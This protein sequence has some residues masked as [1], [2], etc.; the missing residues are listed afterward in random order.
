MTSRVLSSAQSGRRRPA[1]PRT[2]NRL[3]KPVDAP[4][5]PYAD[6]LSATLHKLGP[7]DAIRA[8]VKELNAQAAQ[9]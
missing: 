5:G 2:L 3:Q 7:F 8:K 6:E 9:Q 4:Y 1:S